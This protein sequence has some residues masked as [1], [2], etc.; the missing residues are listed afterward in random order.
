[1]EHRQNIQPDGA[2]AIEAL[3]GLRVAKAV[4]QMRPTNESTLRARARKLRYSIH[5][6]RLRS[7]NEDNLS[8]YALVK[9]DSNSVVLGER[10]DASLEEIAEYL[11]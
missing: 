5:K 6:S 8:K 9:K 10:F 7:I 3:S 11:S 2:T 4:A 1:L